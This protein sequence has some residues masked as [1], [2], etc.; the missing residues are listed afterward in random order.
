MIE[1]RDRFKQKI[2]GYLNEVPEFTKMPPVLNQV[3]IP[4][5]PLLYRIKRISVNEKALAAPSATL[6]AKIGLIR[7]DIT[8]LHLPNGAIVNAANENLTPGGGVCGAIHSAAGPELAE[9]CRRLNG[10]KTGYAKATR[11]YRLPCK[12]IIH[13]V[14]PIYWLAKEMNEHETKLSSCYTETLKLAVGNGLTA[15]AFCALSTGIYGY[16]SYEAAGT[17]ISAVRSFL[18]S[19]DGQKLELVIFCNFEK[20]DEDAYS[21]LI[22]IYFPPAG[23]EKKGEVEKT[24]TVGV[25]KDSEAKLIETN[26]K[27]RIKSNR[28]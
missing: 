23:P 3:D 12:K 11:A 27:L 17:A 8:K 2:D 13:A 16:P 4:T 25:T 7:T 19:E 24:G 20:K 15:V 22:S 26:I 10:C 21:E 9:E 18:E 14:G 5:L 6:N 28:E 1:R